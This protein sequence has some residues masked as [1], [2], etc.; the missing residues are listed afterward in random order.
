MNEKENKVINLTSKPLIFIDINLSLVDIK[1]NENYI[2]IL[3][4][5]IKEIIKLHGFCSLKLLINTVHTICDE[6][7]DFCNKNEE[8]FKITSIKDKGIIGKIVE[9]YL[10]G[11]LPNCDSCPDMIY[12]DIKTTHFKN[13]GLNTQNT[14]NAKERLTLTNFGDPTKQNNIDLIAD[15]NSLQETKFYDKI[16]KGIIL[17]FKH[18]SSSNF[19][20]IENHYQKKIMGIVFYNLNNIFINYPDVANV[21]QNDFEK[22][23]KCIIEKNV[24]QCGQQ[25]LHIHKHGCKDGNTRAFGFTNKFLTKLVSICLKLPLV[26]KGKSDYI[27]FW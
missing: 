13:I 17:I 25:Y 19:E 12:G 6:L 21:F 15:K 27:K 14:F 1:E 26:I 18:E 2:S 22:I 10:F 23:K 20:N 3:N 11:N 5:I 8:K 9:F 7:E 4:N 24:S 16:N